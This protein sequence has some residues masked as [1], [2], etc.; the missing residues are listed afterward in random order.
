MMDITIRLPSLRDK[1][2]QTKEIPIKSESVRTEY[3]PSFAS[4]TPPN[5][6]IATLK[7]RMDVYYSKSSTDNKN[8]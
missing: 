7:K 8:N 6:F 3:E 5:D 2:P 1:L 4:S